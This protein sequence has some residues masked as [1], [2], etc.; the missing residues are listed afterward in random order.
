LY[1]GNWMEGPIWLDAIFGGNNSRVAIVRNRITGWA[2]GKNDTHPIRLESDMDNTAILGNILGTPGYLS[3]V[4]DSYSIDASCIGT[5][6]K[7]NFNTADNGV[8]SSEA[9]GSD[10]I[11]D[12][13]RYPSKPAW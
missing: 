8:N 11:A 2:P 5:V 13:Y 12:S 10:I 6:K 7:G 1:E 9:L 3:V 4:G